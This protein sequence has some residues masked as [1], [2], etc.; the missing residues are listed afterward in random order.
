MD[1]SITVGC[2]TFFW[3]KICNYKIK[4]KMKLKINITIKY[5]NNNFEIKKWVFNFYFFICESRFDILLNIL[6]FSI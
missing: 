6:F 3:I 4:I 2:T 5:I 1:R